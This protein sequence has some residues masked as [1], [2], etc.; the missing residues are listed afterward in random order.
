M[1]EKFEIH[2]TLNPKLWSS[3]NTLLPDVEGRIYSIVNHFKRN[4]SVPIDIVDVHIVGSNASYNYSDTSDVDVHIVAN[5]DSVKAD[6]E[7]VQ[8]LYNLEKSHFNDTYDISLNGV[9]V[10][11]YVEDVCSATVSNGIYSLYRKD[12]IKFPSKITGVKEF[13]IS[14]ELSIWK[15][16]ISNALADDSNDA[17]KLINTLYL[18]RKNSLSVDGEYGKGN[19]L[20]KEIR[21]LGLLDKLKDKARSND[22]KELSLKSL[23]ESILTEDSRASLLTKSK[24]SVKGRQRFNRRNKSRV[25]NSVKQFNSID[26]NKLF[27]QNILTVNISVNGETDN[28]VVRI[29]FGGFL[30]ILHDELK[31]SGE[32]INLKSITRALITG[33][34]KDDVF[35]GCNC[36]LKGDT[37]I[38]LLNGNVVTIAEMYDMFNRGEKLYVYSADENGDFKPGEVSN[39]FIAKYVSDTI[40]VTLDNGKEIETTSDHPYML[41]DGSYMRADELKVGQSLM[42]MY[43]SYHN[44][45]ESYKKNSIT[46]HTEFH[47]VYKEVATTLLG[48]EI[49]EAKNRSG[50]DVIQ[51]HHKDFNKLNNYPD[52]LSPMG[53]NEHWSYHY[54]HLKE[55]GVLDK[56][57]KGGKKYWESD[58]SR[59]KQ[60]KICKKVITNYYANRS[61]DEIERDSVSRSNVSKAAW[62][63]GCFDTEAFHIASKQRGEFLQSPEIRELSKVGVHNYWENLSGDNRNKRISSCLKNI[64]KATNAIKGKPMTESHRNKISAYRNNES[65]EQSYIHNRKITEHK[66]LNVISKCMSIGIPITDENYEKVRLTSFPNG[67]PKV[68]KLF[69]NVDEAVSYFKLN[70]KVVK[71]EYVHYDEPIPVYD[72]TVPNYSNFLTDAGVMLH[73]CDF[74][75]RFGYWTT[76]NGVSSI[77]PENRPSN[78]TNPNDKLGSGCK[79][80]LLVL[81]NNSWI[82]KCASVINN[83]IKYISKNYERLYADVIYPAIYQKPYEG[84][85]QMSIFDNGSDELETDSDTLNKANTHDERD[86]KGRWTKGNNQGVR[87]APNPNRQI[88]GQMTFDELDDEV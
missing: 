19:S 77:D 12:W 68:T 69:K 47:S 3:N 87:F 44:G 41:R 78:I 36:C 22:A 75:Y 63:R 2:D 1:N 29:S 79:H 18:I 38:K 13:D 80:V 40:K 51:I 59:R 55:S 46:D 24:T 71:I 66:M 62:D 39:V 15:E 54:N 28:Y 50:E 16:K 48:K 82:I 4:L 23:G 10:E 6:K 11:L 67:Y 32:E 83:Y 33:F 58:E 20:F 74:R 8:S 72:M 73:N 14:K 5:F 49:E 57:L 52:N 35:I 37:K 84:S 45:Y 34:N 86:D 25:A 60:A 81:S 9:S 27:K 42:P 21:S 70:H 26:M 17:Q 65:E 7:I 53:A 43:F 85:A 31:N 88:D 56:F 30:D 64:E 61:D 76:R